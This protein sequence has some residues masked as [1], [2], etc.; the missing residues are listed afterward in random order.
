M[1]RQNGHIWKENGAWFGRWRENVLVGGRIIRKQR[2]RKLA[3]YCDRYRSESDVRSILDEILRPLNEGTCDARSTALIIEFVT[4]SYMPWVK[5]NCR[6][7]TANGYEKLWH[8]CLLPRLGGKM[9]RDFR[10]VDA[11]NLLSE[12]QRLGQGRR[13][14]Q[15][16]KSLLSGIFKYAKNQGVLDGVNPVKDTII[17]RKAAPPPETHATAPEEMS[18]M[19]ATL[20]EYVQARA[21]IALMFFAGLRPGEARGV[22]WEDYNG[23]TLAVRRSVWRT[24]TT[25]PKTQNSAKPVPA[26]EPLRLILD[27][28]RAAEGNPL[29]GP[30][31]RGAKGGPLNLD[32]LAKKCVIPT[33]KA[34]DIEWHG[35]YAL[36]RGIGTMLTH[37]SH[38]PLAAKGLLRHN[39]L[40]TTL[41]HYVKDV[42]RATMEGM[43]LVERLYQRNQG[44]VQ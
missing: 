10:T 44:S 14:L 42:P 29:T 40:G 28:L 17:P 7:S 24:H 38:D 23:K 37:I 12:L 3:D 33:L 19:L 16:A 21:A 36:R 26:I 18:A 27:E 13:S 8:S 5:E 25:S 6:P 32:N 2:A 41:G 35:W 43:A 1:R 30:I 34:A 39:S 31:L 22:R 9:L 4:S 15:H 11:A 20:N